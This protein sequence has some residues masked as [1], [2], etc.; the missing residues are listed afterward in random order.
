VTQPNHGLGPNYTVH[1]VALWWGV[2]DETVRRW[3]KKGR[4]KATNIGGSRR[5][6]YR[7]SASELN[8]FN[9]GPGVS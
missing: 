2:S 3:I 8:K 7:I 1:E 5:K 4:L 9:I 6:I